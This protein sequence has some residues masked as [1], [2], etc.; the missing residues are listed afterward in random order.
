[1]QSS[2][3]EGI[4][5]FFMIQLATWTSRAGLTSA[6]ESYHRCTDLHQ[7]VRELSRNVSAFYFW[8]TA[9]IR[10]TAVR[11]DLAAIT[12]GYRVLDKVGLDG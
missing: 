1:M 10:L 11:S 2:V 8:T 9:A 7:G 6:N 5:S 12:I 3:S 4:V